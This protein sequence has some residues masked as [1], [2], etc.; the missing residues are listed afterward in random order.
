M[1]NHHKYAYLLLNSLFLISFV[2]FSFPSFGQTKTTKE[3]IITEN[4]V[5][6]KVI[7]RVKD[8]V[9]NNQFLLGDNTRLK[10]GEVFQKFEGKQ[11]QFLYD[12]ADNYVS[13]IIPKLKPSEKYSYSRNGNIVM[14]DPLYNLLLLEIETDGVFIELLKRL[15]SYEE[16]EY[17]Q[18]D[19]FMEST[20]LIPNDSDFVTEQLGFERSNDKDIDAARAWDFNTGNSGIKV[21][22]IDNGIDYH[23]P[24]LGNGAFGISGAIIR[25]GWDYLNN[26]S[27]PDYTEDP[28]YSHGTQCAGLIGAARNNN[29]GVAGL[30]GGNG[31]SNPGVQII[32]LK[33]GPINCNNGRPACLR[34]SLAISAIIEASMNTP[35]FG[36]GCHAI[37]YSASSG[38]YNDAMRNALAVA[39]INDVVFVAS[40]GND[41]TN[42]MRYPADLDSPWVISVGASDENDELAVF[43]NFSNG[44]DVVAPGTHSIVYTTNGTSYSSFGGTSAAAPIV[45]GISSLIISEALDQGILLHPEDVQGII[46]SSAEDVNSGIYPGYDDFLGHGRVNAG[47]A[48]EYLNDPWKINH[49]ITTGGTIVNSSNWYTLAIPRSTGQLV[50]GNYLAKRY[51]VETTITLPQTN[52]DI[53]VWGRGANASVSWSAG[54]PNYQIGYCK[55][56]SRTS[57]TATFQTYTYELKSII[58][59]YLGWFPATPQNVK[60]AYTTLENDCVQDWSISVPISSSTSSRYL[61]S[62]QETITATNIIENQTETVYSAGEEIIFLP[63]FIAGEGCRFLGTIQGCSVNPSIPLT[64]ISTD[65]FSSGERELENLKREVVEIK[66]YSNPFSKSIRVEIPEDV[67]GLVQISLGNIHGIQ[68]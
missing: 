19:Y 59:Q 5:Q 43:S 6:G 67:I 31:A 2:S 54:N 26:D 23:N 36:Y 1:E 30:A 24:D 57:N 9:L 13:K 49:L 66:A 11:N 28:K 46:N 63:G 51:E 20:D 58:G 61:F 29:I 12:F 35:N 50:A 41:T 32:A 52:S 65:Q 15:N 38:S 48:M 60:F 56:K 22:V 34:T 33:V 47:Q 42:A 64:G 44:V 16:I 10:V 45:C 25:G 7:I 21:A 55:L 40:K 3:K 68:F 62:A 27:D 37:N 14:N 17:A 39:A 8:G 18:P 53:F 4:F